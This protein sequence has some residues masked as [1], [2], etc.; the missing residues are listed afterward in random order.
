MN[1]LKEVLIIID[2]QP[3]FTASQSESCINACQ[4]EITNAI[5][6]NNP[7][8]FVEYD[9]D[10]VF[11]N[12]TEHS[13]VTDQRLLSLVDNYSKAFSLLKDDDN[14]SKEIIKILRMLKA[15]GEIDSATQTNLRVCGVNTD[16]CVYKTIKSLSQKLPK[17]NIVLVK[18]ACNSLYYYNH[19]Q[20]LEKKLKLFS[21][22]SQT[23]ALQ[24][25]H[26]ELL[27]A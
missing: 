22:V 19:V 13:K 20:T 6:K 7:I 21:N 12:L 18:D 9:L 16:I 2:M 3:Y 4:L 5:D 15:E 11:K 26:V 25:S 23:T 27:S 14:G 1:F 10:Q 17:S 8:V 24:S